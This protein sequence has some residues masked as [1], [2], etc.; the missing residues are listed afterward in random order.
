MPEAA[1]LLN[2]TLQEAMNAEKLLTQI[3][4]SETDKTAATKAAAYRLSS[5]MPVRPSWRGAGAEPGAPVRPTK[6]QTSV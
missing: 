3:A 1:K 5:T 2:E 6:P 4:K